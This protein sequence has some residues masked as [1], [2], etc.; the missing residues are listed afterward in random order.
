MGIVR[1]QPQGKVLQDHCRRQKAARRRAQ[2]VGAVLGRDRADLARCLIGRCKMFKTLRVRLRALLRNKEMDR[3]LDEEMSLHLERMIEHNVAQGMTRD[4]ARFAAL[5]DFGGFQQA[6]EECLDARGLRA[7]EDVWQDL[8]YGARMLLKNPG[9][10]VIA[11]LTLALGIGAN[12]A[13]FSVVNAVLLNPLPFA[14]SDKLMALGQTSASNRVALS[15]FSFLNFA[16][17]R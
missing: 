8:R 2:G 5:R 12:T 3:E 9:F 6:K 1:K 11:V 10:T 4:D 14:A 17:L 7:L 15:N 16:D 13:I